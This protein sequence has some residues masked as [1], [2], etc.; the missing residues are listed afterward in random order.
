[1]DKVFLSYAREDS[2]IALK[3]YSDLKKEGIDVWLDKEKLIPGQNW[4]FAISQAIKESTHFLALFSSKSV[5][6]RGFYQKELKKALDVLDEMPEYEIYFIPVRLD[7]CEPASEKLQDIHWADLFP[8]YQ[9]GLKQILKV[10]QIQKDNVTAKTPQEHLPEDEPSTGKIIKKKKLA[11]YHCRS[12]PLDVSEDDA[13]SVFKLNE[14]WRPL[15][16]VSNEYKE[17]GDGTINDHA[18]GLI[19]QQSGSD[20][21]TYKNAQKY[22]QKLNRKKFAGFNDWR[23]PTVEELASLLEAEERSDD[24]YID[25]V[26][27]EN[28]RWCWSS[29]TVKGSSGLAWVVGF[30][31]GLVLRSHLLYNSYVRV[32]RAGQ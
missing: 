31:L 5:S 15:R 6:K 26:F 30:S 4:K 12:K 29:D 17:N 25:P 13:L 11:L 7:E 27:D 2:E 23:L 18:T 21:L 10:F 28:Q 8:S 3:L 1:M 22:V 16:Y 24:L 20:W 19:W 32:V 14:N 9:E